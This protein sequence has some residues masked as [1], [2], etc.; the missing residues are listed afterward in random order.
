M[1]ANAVS[2]TMTMR[3]PGDRRRAPGA[4]VRSGR[5]AL[6]R[7]RAAYRA[8]RSPASSSLAGEH[9]ERGAVFRG[10]A[11]RV[12]RTVGNQG[13][14]HRGCLRGAKRLPDDPAAHQVAVPFQGGEM[15]GIAGAALASVGRLSGFP[16]VRCRSRFGMAR[17]GAGGTPWGGS[18]VRR[19]PS[20]NRRRGSVTNWKSMQNQRH[21]PNH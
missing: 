14:L 12:Q 19:G 2:P 4:S 18:P 5:P 15:E 8:A 7:D 1:V 17:A 9:P 10:S 6:F 16:P 3:R 21:K 11:E 20:R 13:Q